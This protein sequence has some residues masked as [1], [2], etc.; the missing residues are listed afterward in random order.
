MYNQEN[1]IN[2]ICWFLNQHIVI[3]TC[4]W[5][6]R[7]EK[8]IS[9]CCR[10]G[11]YPADLGTLTKKFSVSWRRTASLSHTRSTF[12]C[13]FDFE[14][15][16]PNSN[17]KTETNCFPVGFDFPFFFL[18]KKVESIVYGVEILRKWMIEE[19]VEDLLWR[20]GECR[21]DSIVEVL[22]ILLLVYSFFLSDFWFFLSFLFS[23]F[24]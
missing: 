13:E 14:F 24:A 17:W 18:D 15:R 9:K 19:A 21:K 4:I 1:S 5:A 3:G 23:S 11:W 20:W 8:F 16:L 10:F 12:R 7:R 2:I 6:A 22:A